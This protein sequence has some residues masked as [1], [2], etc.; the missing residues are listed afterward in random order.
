[1]KDRRDDKMYEIDVFWITILTHLYAFV[2]CYTMCYRDLSH[3]Y[4]VS[5]PEPELSRYLVCSGDLVWLVSHSTLFPPA[6]TQS[7]T[8]ESH[9]FSALI[10]CQSAVLSSAT[11]QFH[12]TQIKL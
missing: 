5:L 6:L 3:D 1:M 4:L 2:S 7:I 12:K 11:H 8:E 10:V 9:R